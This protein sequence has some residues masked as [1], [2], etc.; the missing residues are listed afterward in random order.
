[1]AGGSDPK[2]GAVINWRRA[3]EAPKSS[4]TLFEQ[5]PP[6]SV[7][8]APSRRLDL[9]PVPALA[10][11][12]RR[13]SALA[14]YTLEAEPIGLLEQL[15][16]VIEARDQVQAWHAR[17][18]QQPLQPSPALGQGKLPEIPAVPMQ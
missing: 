15:F 7:R 16:S 17:P 3:L 1:M 8:C 6:R 12:V 14:H 10:G 13:N 9:A 4:S 2:L 11:P 5:P 18:G